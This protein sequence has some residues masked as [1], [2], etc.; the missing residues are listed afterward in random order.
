MT[1]DTKPYTNLH[2]F[3]HIHKMPIQ[4]VDGNW[5]DKKV[6][7]TQGLNYRSSLN[8]WPLDPH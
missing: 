6:C 7:G 1:C 8:I 5:F 2:K 4:K 3:G